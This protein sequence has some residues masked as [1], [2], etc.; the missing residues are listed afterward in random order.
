M[1]RSSRVTRQCSIPSKEVKGEGDWRKT[2]RGCTMILCR[3]GC[4]R[5]FVINSNPFHDQNRRINI[6]TRKRNRTKS[7]MSWRNKNWRI[8][9]ISGFF[10]FKHHA[11]NPSLSIVLVVDRVGVLLN[12]LFLPS[13]W[14]TFLCTIANPQRVVA[15][16]W[17]PSVFREGTRVG[18]KGLARPLSPLVLVPPLLYHN[19][20]SR[21]PSRIVCSCGKGCYV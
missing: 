16:P 19:I 4:T 15:A 9:G 20:I 7:P 12:P 8:S 3:H 14:P 18:G 1:P 21:L 2:A 11:L 17:N 6:R 13:Q 10:F 5:K